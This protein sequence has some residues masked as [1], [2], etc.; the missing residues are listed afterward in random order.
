MQS[1]V[2]TVIGPDRPGLVERVSEV[3]AGHGGSWQESRMV[4]LAGRFAGVLRV[5]VP[6]DR[7]AA[8]EAGLA[9][10]D[11]LRIGVETSLPDDESAD[12]GRSLA[13]ELVGQD[14]PGIVHDIS[15]ALALHGVNVIEL[16]TE[17]R[18]APMS[19]DLLFHANARLSVPA[20][21]AIDALSDRL[22]KI[23]NDLMVDIRIEETPS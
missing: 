10:L 3:V 2:L 19:G 17:C 5:A 1:L 14:R 8:V 21:V 9:R 15:E 4:R 7:V 6:D 20:A 11:G 18:S 13:L 23:A 12:I 16:R 22:E